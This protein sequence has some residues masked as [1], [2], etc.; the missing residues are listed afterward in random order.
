MLCYSLVVAERN[1]LQRCSYSEGAAVLRRS[2]GFRQCGA[3]GKAH[4]KMPSYFENAENFFHVFVTFIF[5]N[6]FWVFATLALFFWLCRWSILLIVAPMAAINLHWTDVMQELL[7]LSLTCDRNVNN[8][9]RSRQPLLTRA[10]T[11]PA[12]Y[13]PADTF[14]IPLNS[15][16]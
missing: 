8:G 5:W 7:N 9:G 3:M 16:V 13:H 2:P 6:M 11:P 12:V 1:D 14:W 15:L 4:S 10:H